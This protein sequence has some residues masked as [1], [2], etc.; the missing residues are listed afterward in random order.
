MRQDYQSPDGELRLFVIEDRD[1][2]TIGFE[3]VPWHTH[4]D[5]IAGE[6]ALLGM[7]EFSAASAAR[8]FVVDLLNDRVLVCVTRI[9]GEIEDI[10][11]SYSAT[12]AEDD[13]PAH[14]TVELR[15]WSGKPFEEQKA[16]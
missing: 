7:G 8:R 1:D 12:C 15:T 6:L 9:G 2:I 11:A 14:E 13:V 4:G 10:S 16:E 3:S 5:V